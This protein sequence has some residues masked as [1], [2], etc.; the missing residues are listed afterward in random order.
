MLI[1]RCIPLQYQHEILVKAEETGEAH[2][3]QYQHEIL[4]K[5]EEIGEAIVKTSPNPM[6]G[7]NENQSEKEVAHK[8]KELII[9]EPIVGASSSIKKSQIGQKMKSKK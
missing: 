3:L 6:G 5:A 8:G 1:F 2:P 9:K 4:V 7:R